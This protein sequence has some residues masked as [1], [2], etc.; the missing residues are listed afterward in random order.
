MSALRFYYDVVCPY[1]YLASVQVEA[2]AARG[3]AT[4]SW[5]PVLLG[6]LFRKVAAPQVPAASM[7]AP[8]AR[9]NLLDMY[10]C[11]DR[12]G[13]P[14]TM[15]SAHP[16]RTVEAMRLL[17]GVGEGTTR[18]ALT[19]ALYRAYWGEGRD[20]SD[21]AVLDAIA[22]EHG[23]DPA[24]I[25]SPEAREGLFASTAEASALGA[26][27]VPTF[28]VGEN[29]KIWWGQDRLPLVEEA[30]GHRVRR[31]GEAGAAAGAPSRA[32]RTSRTPRTS[33]ASP[34]PTSTPS[35]GT[36]ATID[37]F[38]DFASPYAYLAATQIDRVAAAWGATVRWRP[39]LLGALFREIG[40]AD[41]PLFEVSAEKQR[42]IRR[43]LTDWAT[44]WGVPFRFPSH[45]P[46]RSIAPL[47]AALVAPE[48][49]PTLYR[50][51][52]SED[53]A[54]DDPE[55]LARVIADAGH[56]AAAILEAT[57][58]PEIKA[59]LRAN[60]AAAIEAGCCGAPSMVVIPGGGEEGPIL[61]WGQDRLDMLEDVLAGWRPPRG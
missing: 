9:F 6:G 51:T 42:Y 2:A 46:L 58:R 22:R 1:A 60:T 61:L 57:K 15:P 44:H 34:S 21:R 3:G 50:A 52:W 54:V 40:C 8:R 12:L 18:V 37:F 13:L 39:I 4:V 45:F 30:L 14:L 55:V 47:R 53:H 41:V 25:D 7:S 31:P 38:H 27:G 43:D 56:D 23:V 26:F 16:R 29:E 59:E 32:P 17:V 36:G 10:R 5:R 49:T 20:V 11:A 33:R 19:A 28:A 48:L 24:L 35:A